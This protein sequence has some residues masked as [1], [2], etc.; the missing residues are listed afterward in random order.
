M[1]EKIK[2]IE[3]PCFRVQ[4]RDKVMY[5]CP[6]EKCDLT[7]KKADFNS[8]K[9]ELKMITLAKGVTRIKLVDDLDE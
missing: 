9:K 5:I 4:I 1:E 7:K 6:R 8:F 3:T 2:T